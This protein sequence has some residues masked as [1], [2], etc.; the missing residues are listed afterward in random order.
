MY[1]KKLLTCKGLKGTFS[2]PFQRE[3]KRH[4][5][6]KISLR[7]HKKK[8]ISVVHPITSFKSKINIIFKYNFKFCL[9]LF[10]FIIN[11]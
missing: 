6:F 2:S 11:A 10:V 7:G 8:S 1:L 3:N 9:Y 4:S 5:I